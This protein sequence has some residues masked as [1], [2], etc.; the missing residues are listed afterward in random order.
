V[1]VRALPIEG[2][3]IETLR[4]KIMGKIVKIEDSLNEINE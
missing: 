1:C 2:K 3:M 4:M